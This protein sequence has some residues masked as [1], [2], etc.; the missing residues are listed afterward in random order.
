MDYKY[1]Y[2]KYKKKYLQLKNKIYGGSNS[3][4]NYINIINDF[5]KKYLQ[6]F[7]YEPENSYECKKEEFYNVEWIYKDT[8]N[9]LNIKNINDRLYT[10]IINICNYSSACDINSMNSE[11][12]IEDDNIKHGIGPQQTHIHVSLPNIEYKD[13]NTFI[14]DIIYLVYIWTNKYQLYFK[15]NFINDYDSWADENIMACGKPV[16]FSKSFTIN[17]KNCIKILDSNYI[18]EET[19]DNKFYATKKITEIKNSEGEIEYKESD[20]KIY[21]LPFGL[22]LYKLYNYYTTINFNLLEKI[23]DKII[24]NESKEIEEIEEIDEIYEYRYFDLNIIPSINTYLNKII[25][26]VEFRAL[27]NL[28]NIGGGLNDF[29]KNKYTNSTQEYISDSPFLYSFFQEFFSKIEELFFNF[30]KFKYNHIIK[31][32]TINLGYF[33]LKNE[34]KFGLEIETCANIKKIKRSILSNRIQSSQ[35]SRKSPSRGEIRRRKRRLETP[36]SKYLL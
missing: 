17:N 32:N 33:K 15:E 11:Y 29:Y 14:N 19:K 9:Y 5:E 16:V 22:R 28:V 4:I 26:R 23:A 31:P 25:F 24:D 13:R 21:N 6:V 34:L 18:L 12:N 35:K 36:Y 8:F 2:I 3:R 27:N 20:N 7:K 1:K 10:D 30:L